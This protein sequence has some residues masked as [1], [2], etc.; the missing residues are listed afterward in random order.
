M[1][2]RLQDK[3]IWWKQINYKI[4]DRVF[5][6]QRYRGEPLP[7]VWTPDGK[8]IALD[9]KDLPLLLPDVENY[10]PTGTT[11]WPLANIDERVNITLP[12]G[13]KAT[14]ET[15]TM[16]G[17]AGSSR[18]RLRYMDPKNTKQLVSPE[19]EKYRG[20]VDVYVGG[21]EHVTR[22]MIY[23]RFWQKFL[24]DLGIVTHDE[25]FKEYHYVGLI[26]AEDGRKMSKRRWNTIDPDQVIGEFGHDTFRVY[27]MFMG[28]F[29]Q[30]IARSTNGVKWAK[31]FLDKIIALQSKISN[32]SSFEK[33]GGEH[34]ETK[35]L[36]SDE[37]K[38]LLNQTIKKITDDID[39]FKF[40]TCISQLMILVNHLTDLPSIDKKTFEI[41]TILI[42]PFAPHLAEELR[43]LLGNEFSI[44]TKAKWPSYDEKCL[45]SATIKIWVQF[46][47]KVRGDICINKE[48][49][50][51]EVMAIVKAD[52]KL[53]A[54]LT[55]EPKKIIY[56]PGKILNIVI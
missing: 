15:N 22:H 42:S 38:T 10:E 25:P 19:R 34:S 46:N 20:E 16:P 7:I 4:Q 9:E 29:D 50:Q 33:G 55:G 17:R 54:R 1:Q 3:K 5:S 32:L 44:F 24:Y 45:T 18:Y 13:T 30:A 47:G 52:A 27:E 39:G 11:E 6:R 43:S 2:K 21:A 8:A 53:N 51:D 41:L 37:T 49:T 48:T 14:R 28:P 40:N 12:D 35:D 56:V 23:A 26:M 31:K 36:I